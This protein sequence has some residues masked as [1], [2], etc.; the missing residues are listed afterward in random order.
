MNRDFPKGAKDNPLDSLPP[1]VLQAQE[2]PQRG[3]KAVGGQHAG[4]HTHHDWEGRGHF[5][6]LPNEPQASRVTSIVEPTQKGRAVLEKKKLGSRPRGPLGTVVYA[7]LIPVQSPMQF[8][9]V[10]ELHFPSSEVLLMLCSL[11]S[12]PIAK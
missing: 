7:A 2:T 6:H 11:R 8:F 12:S 5:L 9:Q 4:A 3:A 1:T 10:L